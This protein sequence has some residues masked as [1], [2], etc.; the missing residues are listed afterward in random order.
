MNLLFKTEDPFLFRDRVVKAH[1]TRTFTESLIKYN[2]YIDNMSIEE[3]QTLNGEQKWRLVFKA[4]NV[5]YINKNINPD[6]SPWFMTYVL[7]LQGR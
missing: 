6:N 7:I 3:I 5:K 1:Q 2:F 4:T